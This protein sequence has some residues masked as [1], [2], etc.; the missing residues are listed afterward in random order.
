VAQ[1]Y[2]DAAFSPE[3]KARCEAMVDELIAAM[4]RAVRSADW[5]TDET[6]A[7]ALTKVS[8]FTAKIGYPDTWR[9]YSDLEITPDVH[10]ANRMRAAAF[11]T[12]RRLG[13]LDEPVDT[14]EWEMPAHMVNAYYNPLRNEIVFPAGILQPPMFWADG[15]DAGNFGGIGTVIGHEI[16]HGFD[17]NGSKFDDQ[18]RFRMWWTEEDRGEFDR[19]A[20]VLAEQVNAYPLGEDLAVNGRLT[21]GENLADLGGLKIAF[22]AWRH[23]GG[24]DVDDVG[25]HTPAQRFFL[26]YATIW[27]MNYTPEYLQLLLNVDVHAPSAVRVNVPVSNLAA[28]AEAFDLGDQATLRLPADDR[29]EIW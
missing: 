17:D 21:L 25:G 23:A 4:E 12:E 18:G 13:R 5:M 6:R 9:D 28:F 8:T 29:V 3:A 11:E 1:L 2:V 7:A 16:T 20:T 15:D 24:R 27:R 14:T 22:D 26:A 19:R 10:V